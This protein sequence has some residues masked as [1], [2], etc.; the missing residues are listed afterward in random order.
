MVPSPAKRARCDE[1]SRRT[2]PCPANVEEPAAKMEEEEKEQEEEGEE[3]EEGDDAAS[4]LSDEE[5]EA[6]TAAIAGSGD[7][8]AAQAH[9]LG[10]ALVPRRD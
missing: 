1:D 8:A 4:S 10:R 2:R 3:G 9:S 6:A 7:E 5:R